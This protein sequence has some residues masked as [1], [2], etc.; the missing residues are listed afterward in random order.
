[1]K[2][3]FALAVLLQMVLAVSAQDITG[4]WKTTITDEGQSIPCTMTFSAKGALTVNASMSQK[5]PEV[6]TIHINVKFISSYKQEGDKLTV[7]ADPKKSYAEVTSIDFNTALKVAMMAQPGMDKQVVDMMNQELRKR[8][9]DMVKE[10]PLDG[11]VTIKE[12]TDKKLVL[13]NNGTKIV[14]TR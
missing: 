5:D 14:L 6:G 7:T 11:E 3:L 13:V 9:G 10:A 8:S 12:V 1:M 2:K 4:K